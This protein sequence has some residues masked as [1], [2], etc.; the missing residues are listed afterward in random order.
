V[1]PL[2]V[3][4]TVVSGDG[5]SCTVAQQGLRGEFRVFYNVVK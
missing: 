3:L 2:A 5:G 4:D 1:L